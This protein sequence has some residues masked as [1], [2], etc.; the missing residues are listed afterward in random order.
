MGTGTVMAIATASEAELW[1][2]ARIGSL[3]T[4]TQAIGIQRHQAT[5]LELFSGN[6]CPTTK[7]IREPGHSGDCWQNQH[8]T[9][10][11]GRSSRSL[12]AT[13]DVCPRIHPRSRS[14]CA[15]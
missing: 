11:V 6:T 1:L 8:T 10:D 3:E 4:P 2:A 14:R 15:L 12:A 9:S 7:T 5:V 13:N